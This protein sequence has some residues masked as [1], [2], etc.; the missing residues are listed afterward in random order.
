MTD[1]S[2]AE[3]VGKPT[4]ATSMEIAVRNV[5]ALFNSLEPS[6]FRDK[7]L[8]E[9]AVKFIESWAGEHALATPLSLCIQVREWPSEDPSQMI[10]DAEH[11][12]FACRSKLVAME[13]SQLMKQA[14]TSLL[15]GLLFLTIGVIVVNYFLAYKEGTW[16]KIL[17]ESLII[18]G[19][20]V[21]WR[22]LELYLYDWWPLRSKR[23]LY[24]KL[25][26]I[27]VEVTQQPEPLSA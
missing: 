2:T 20:V 16:V 12:C 27:P 22:P 17:S 15:I 10:R 11:N 4:S 21:M 23:R 1:R 3:N 18:A 5:D 8:D 25:S 13:F 24:E 19:W 6:P 7:D 9:D 14:R 26:A